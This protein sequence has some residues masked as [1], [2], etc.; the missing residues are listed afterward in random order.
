MLELACGDG[1]V[2]EGGQRLRRALRESDATM[3][4][5]ALLRQ[6]LHALPVA[7]LCDGVRE[8]MEEHRDRSLVVRGAGHGERTREQV[9]GNG[10]VS[11]HVLHA[12]LHTQ[13]A[14][15]EAVGNTQ[16]FSSRTAAQSLPSCEPFVAQ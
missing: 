3:A 10:R 7:A 2:G 11:V 9:L 8:A 5:E 6:C 13:R 16:L 12:A 14:Q 15:D 1:D 4:R